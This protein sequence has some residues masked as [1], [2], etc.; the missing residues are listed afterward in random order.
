MTNSLRACHDLPAIDLH[1]SD[2]AYFDADDVLRLKQ[3]TGMA[4][5]FEDEDFSEAWEI[6]A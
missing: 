2:S 1:Y 5:L 3:I 4:E 6:E